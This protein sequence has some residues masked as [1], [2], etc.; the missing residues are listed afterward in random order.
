[1]SYRWRKG[2]FCM[3]CL[4]YCRVGLL[5]FDFVGLGGGGFWSGWS[6]F[7]F[8]SLLFFSFP[9]K[10]T[11][12]FSTSRAECRHLSCI[13]DPFLI[14]VWC[15]FFCS[16]KK[17]KQRNDWRIDVF[18]LCLSFCSSPISVAVLGIGGR[19]RVGRAKHRL[20][21]RQ[22]QRRRRLDDEVIPL[23]LAVSDARGI[24][25][26]ATTRYHTRHT[27]SLF[28]RQRNSLGYGSW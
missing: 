23:C 15:F 6:V 16:W 27:H 20:R 2:L 9:F 3:L 25:L 18:C 28:L 26:C 12:F 21:D 1:M 19:R 7:L 11:F 8:V 10:V 14:P 4:E 22:R 5:A 17:R 13:A 24:T